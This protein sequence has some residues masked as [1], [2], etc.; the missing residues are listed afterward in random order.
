MTS[1][2]QLDFLAFGRPSFADDEIEAVA[3]L[4][5]SDWTGTDE[6]QGF[7]E[8]L[9]ACVGA[10][11]VV[12]VNSPASALF[13]SLSVLNLKPGDEV[14]CPSLA[15]CGTANAALCLG[16]QP[17]FC[18]VDPVTLSATPE[19]VA[20][21]VTA[22][23]R[24]VIVV[25]TGGLAADVAALRAALPAH[26]AIV[27]DA[28]HA[29]GARYAD[30]SPVGSSGN[31]T[32]FSVHATAS[33]SPGEGA[34][35]ASVEADIAH[36]LR[37]LRQN[38]LQA[39][40]WSRFTHRQSVLIP[41]I[42]DLGSRMNCTELQASIGRVQL[43]RLPELAYQRQL[44]A[45]QYVEVLNSL[46]PSLE[47]QHGIAHPGHAR[48]LLLVKLPSR[49]LSMSRNDLLAALRRRHVS[50]TV[51]YQSLHTMAVY[52]AAHHATSPHPTLPHTEALA[53][54]L[55]ALPINGNMASAD[56]DYVVAQLLD[57]LSDARLVAIAS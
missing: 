20:R 36:R 41:G 31:L 39:D 17:V 57:V 40:A 26:V 54:R 11:H 48:H 55:L 27:E 42:A 44:L 50:A 37:A 1:S 15:C 9:A 5:Q 45:R 56:V 8:H 25:H 21:H 49:A 30:G 7:E 6:T 38:G 13:L 2:S 28:T 34:A 43:R 24:A 46:E 10:P 18:D 51:P 35:V 14:I 47:F 52:R 16:A 53:H 33:D 23:T 22:R 19:T 4:T 29:M 12:S 3:R 32:C